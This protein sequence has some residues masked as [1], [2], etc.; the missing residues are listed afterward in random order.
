MI[1]TVSILCACCSISQAQNVAKIWQNPQ[2]GLYA[3]T[4]K[5]PVHAPNLVLVSK[6]GKQ[7]LIYTDEKKQ[8]FWRLNPCESEMKLRQQL[9]KCSNFEDVINHLG[10][11]SNTTLYDAFA[12]VVTK[13]W[14]V[15]A[16]DGAKIKVFGVI[17]EQQPDR[18]IAIEVEVV[19]QVYNLADFADYEKTDA[20]TNI[21]MH[22][23]L[24]AKEPFQAKATKNV[25]SCYFSFVFKIDRS[26]ESSAQDRQHDLVFINEQKKHLLKCLSY[27]NEIWA[28][29]HIKVTKPDFHFEMVPSGDE[30]MQ[31]EQPAGMMSQ[32]VK[33]LEVLFTRDKKLL[34]DVMHRWDARQQRIIMH[35][36][37]PMYAL[38][39]DLGHAAG[40]E[41]CLDGI[42]SDYRA[43]VM[44]AEER[45]SEE[46]DMV[47][48]LYADKVLK[49]LTK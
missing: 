35:P 11:D 40:Y 27:C 8:F 6:E 49:F 18:K 36:R 33:K 19:D 12:G 42:H 4:K 37:A 41:G 3:A 29:T 13:K 30:N 47:D 28:K 20:A 14:G 16:L 26:S 44:S 25:S 43:N 46:C 39:H 45:I 23:S 17:A 24:V 15:Y 9:A 32:G 34:G 31:Q 2:P 21:T 1:K 7:V 10:S 38:A 22:E 5:I 48:G